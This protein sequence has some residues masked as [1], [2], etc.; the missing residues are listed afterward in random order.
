MP[1]IHSMIQ[2]QKQAGAIPQD[3]TGLF[4]FSC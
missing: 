2:T 4:A 1:T 3:R